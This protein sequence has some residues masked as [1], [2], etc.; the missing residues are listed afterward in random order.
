MNKKPAKETTLLSPK[1]D[2]VFKCI[3][4]DPDNIDLLAALLKSI[5]D[6]PPNE[7]ERIE[8][9]NPF[10]L[11]TYPS[12][13]QII[14]DVKVHTTSGKVLDVEIQCKNRDAFKNRIVYCSSKLLNAQLE[15]GEGYD[16]I[17][18]VIAI[19]IT[20]FVLLED[21][22][23]YHNKFHIRNDKSGKLF[24]DIIE[25]NSLELPKLPEISDKTELWDFMR[26]LNAETEDEMEAVAKENPTI[27]KTVAVVKKLSRDE[28]ARMY[29]EARMQALRDE[30][31]GRLYALKQGIEEGLKQG[32]EQ[33]LEQGKAVG[34]EEGERN[35]SLAIVAI[36]RNLK[37]KNMSVTDIVDIT[38]LPADEIEAL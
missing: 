3:F 23:D 36:A 10:S 25:I 8:I 5:L 11:K 29:A 21:E 31:S 4:G 20:D 16:K 7:Y 35:K 30:E 19:V 38:G 18:Q 15:S 14:L 6:L 9:V 37:N 28:K 27:R 32:L 26:F 1:L 17:E 13:K 34:R 12:E 22:P 24:S 2:F 33:G